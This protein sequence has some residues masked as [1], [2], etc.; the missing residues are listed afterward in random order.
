MRFLYRQENRQMSLCGW[1]FGLLASSFIPAWSIVMKSFGWLIFIKCLFPNFVQNLEQILTKIKHEEGAEHCGKTFVHIL[2]E[3]C[4]TCYVRST[5]SILLFWV[6]QKWTL[7]QLIYNFGHCSHWSVQ[8]HQSYKSCVSCVVTG[9]YLT[10]MIF[11]ICKKKHVLWTL[12][13]GI[14]REESSVQE[15]TVNDNKWKC[16]IVKIFLL[17][18]N[19]YYFKWFYF[20]LFL[21]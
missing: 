13:G 2:E 8:M 20:Q 15:L 6:W 12:Q 11:I 19:L 7:A 10:T 3:V 21:S 5:D 9:G 16:Y 14:N 1:E 4:C 17:F 18:L